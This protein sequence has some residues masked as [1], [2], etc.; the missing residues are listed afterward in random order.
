MNP[1]SVDP[2]L[3]LDVPSGASPTCTE[4]VEKSPIF[5][6]NL[7]EQVLLDYGQALKLKLQELGKIIADKK[8]LMTIIF[9]QCN[10]VTKTK[11][12]LGAS[13]LKS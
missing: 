13:L 2:I 7:Q 4:M 9:K 1:G 6:S 5:D 8:A 11:I 3:G 10:N 12:A